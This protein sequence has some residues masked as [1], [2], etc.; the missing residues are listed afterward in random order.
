MIERCVDQKSGSDFTLAFV[1]RSLAPTSSNVDMIDPVSLSGRVLW[2]CKKRFLR[3]WMLDCTLCWYY[4]VISFHWRR[5]LAV[6]L[7]SWAFFCWSLPTKSSTAYQHDSEMVSEENI[8]KSLL[9]SDRNEWFFVGRVLETFHEHRFS[10]DLVER[11]CFRV[12]HER[13]DVA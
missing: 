7:L 4:F 3:C 2:R 6:W 12:E 11:Q 8:Q 1:L 5:S 10:K 13:I 9:P